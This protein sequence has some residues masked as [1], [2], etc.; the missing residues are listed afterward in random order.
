MAYREVTIL[1]IWEIVRRWHSGQGIREIARAL[2]CDRNTVRR[3]TRLARSAGVTREAPL[4]AREQ[5]LPLLQEVTSPTRRLPQAQVLL[6]PYLDE[7]RQLTTDPDL[8]LNEKSAFI[9]ICQRH[10]LTVSYSS[11]KRFVAAHREKIDPRLA[12][13][14]LEVPPGAEVQLDYAKVGLFFDALTERRRT[15]YVFIGTLSHSR[16]KYVEL[17]YSQDQMSFVSSHVRMFAFFS[18]VPERLVLD[19][20]KSGVIKPDLYDPTFNRTYR[21]MAEH[22]GCFL[23]PARVARPKD[24]GKVERDVQT[25]REAV[26]RII[27]LNPSI[28][29]GELNREALLWSKQEYGLH[30]HG[31]TGEKPLVVFTERE[32]PAL[33]PLPSESFEV[34]CWKQATVH[35]DHYVQYRGKAFSVPTAYVTKKVWLQATEHLLK[36]FYDERLI[37]QHLITR[38]YRHTDHRHFPENMRAAL[39]KSSL[40]Q[41]LLERSRTSGGEDFYR[42]IQQLFEV[43]AFVNLRRAQGLVATAEES[44]APA[45]VNRA[46]RFM[47]EYRVRATPHELRCVLEKLR[48]EAEQERS[49]GALA[50]LSEEFVRDV[51]YFINHPQEEGNA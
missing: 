34:S 49:A 30:P 27:V 3:Y 33:R 12:T 17:T 26:R 38:S 20:L 37:A 46:A 4:P 10:A 50:D 13:C 24:K 22:Y 11:F 21:D 14:R 39:D 40:H 42:M 8:G 7:V 23:D 16:L 41:H 29:L 48:S 32:K 2:E 51:G 1:D 25:V 9:V 36:V 18:G 19:N 35:P 15:L 44:N 5:L 31:T 45:L 6:S 47:C 28:T 43:D